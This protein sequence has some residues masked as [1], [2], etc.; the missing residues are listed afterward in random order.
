MSSRITEV[1]RR[2]Y[3]E[4]QADPVAYQRLQ[5]KARWEHMTP[6][7]ILREWG[8]PRKWEK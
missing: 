3:A 7:A 6:F 1:E 2:L 8:D 4:V 5:E